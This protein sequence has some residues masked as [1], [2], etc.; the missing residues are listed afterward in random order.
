MTTTAL[1][2]RLSKPVLVGLLVLAGGGWFYYEVHWRSSVE[3]HIA[4]SQ[5]GYSRLHALE[6]EVGSVKGDI[7]G[8]KGEVRD[9]R[10]DQLEFYRWQAER[11]GDTVRA[12]ALNEKLG[13]VK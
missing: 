5:D 1:L 13:R 7:G 9:M 3:A 10:K 4:K 8:L 6:S 11:V 12:R 2:Q